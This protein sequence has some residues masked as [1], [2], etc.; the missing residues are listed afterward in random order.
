MRILCTETHTHFLS[1]SLSVCAYV[2]I[3]LFCALSA[4]QLCAFLLLLDVKLQLFTIVIWVAV[5]ELM[6]FGDV[7]HFVATV[8]LSACHDTHPP[9]PVHRCVMNLS[10]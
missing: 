2:I 8:V 6:R 5:I 10:V 4:D 1:L 3:L 9:P 7:V